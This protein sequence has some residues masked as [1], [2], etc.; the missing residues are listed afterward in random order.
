MT[1]RGRIRRFVGMK[2][3]EWFILFVVLG[4]SITLV[5]NDWVQ[6]TDSRSRVMIGSKAVRNPVILASIYSGLLAIL[7]LKHFL[8]FEN[9]DARNK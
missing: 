4:S 6:A 1:F 3:F 8:F 9:F 7:F 2:Y 5:S